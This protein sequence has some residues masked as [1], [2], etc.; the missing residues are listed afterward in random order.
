LARGLFLGALMVALIVTLNSGSVG[1]RIIWC[2]FGLL[3]GTERL[4]RPAVRS[5][6]QDVNRDGDPDL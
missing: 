5:D 1:L 3:A 4:L 6:N 2:M